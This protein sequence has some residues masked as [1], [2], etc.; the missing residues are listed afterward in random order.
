MYRYLNIRL[1]ET[2]SE[3]IKT[4]EAIEFPNQSVELINEGYLVYKNADGCPW[5]CV[6]LLV[7]DQDGNF[8]SNTNDKHEKMP[9]Q[10]NLWVDS[11]SGSPPMV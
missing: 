1:D 4:T 7:A 6:N 11:G 9:L 2:Y 8:A 5:I 3:F 10:Q